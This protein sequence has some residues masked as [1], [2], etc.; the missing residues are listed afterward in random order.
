MVFCK[1]AKQVEL[2]NSGECDTKE[3]T[4]LYARFDGSQPFLLYTFF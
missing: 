4:L 1:F 3:V 2:C